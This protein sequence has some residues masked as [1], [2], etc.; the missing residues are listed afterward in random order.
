MSC[1][2]KSLMPLPKG[3]KVREAREGE[4]ETMSQPDQPGGKT[5]PCGRCGGG[6]SSVLCG[7]CLEKELYYLKRFEEAVLKRMAMEPQHSRLD[8]DCELCEALADLRH[9]RVRRG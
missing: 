4:A 7:T 3:E 9:A 5:E 1:E 8:H 6:P 2:H